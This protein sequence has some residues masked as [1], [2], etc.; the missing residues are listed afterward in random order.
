MNTPPPSTS[1]TRPEPSARPACRSTHSAAVRVIPAPASRWASR[2]SKSPLTTVPAKLT[3]ESLRLAGPGR[4]RL[5]EVRR[6]PL[7]C[8][9]R[10]PSA[11]EHTAEDGGQPQG[12]ARRAPRTSGGDRV[13]GAAPPAG[14]LRP[15]R[16]RRSGTGSGVVVRRAV[17]GQGDLEADLVRGLARGLLATREADQ[18]L[19]GE[20][21]G[22]GGEHRPQRR[23]VDGADDLPPAGVRDPRQR[24]R[25]ALSCST[26][27][28]VDDDPPSATA[29]SASSSGTPPPSSPPSESRRTLRAPSLPV[30]S[31]AST[32]AEYSRCRASAGSPRWPRRGPGG[33][34]WADGS[35][36]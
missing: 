24:A 7:L 18:H 1:P 34:W 21:V 9:G 6:E 5:P 35:L 3:T 36:T 20:G 10:T 23:R 33:R 31:T 2:D 26:A 27:T 12:R 16:S 4:V 30:R 15:R 25:S 13:R 17:G 32:T 14:R 8:G 11:E 29:S 28:A 19:V 22:L